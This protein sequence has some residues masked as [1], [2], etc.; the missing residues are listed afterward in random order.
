MTDTEPVTLGRTYRDNITGFV[1]TATAR[2]EYLYGCVRVDLE[3]QVVQDGDVKAW[4]F[5]E[6]R[7]VDPATN[8]APTPT[9]TSG[10]AR[11]AVPAR[12]VGARLSGR[13]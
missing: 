4:V 7:L 2:H 1:G 13:R 8:Q 5:D 12:S 9:A 3:G 11:P 6:Q 10:G